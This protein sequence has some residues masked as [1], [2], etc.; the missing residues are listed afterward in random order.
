MCIDIEEYKIKNRELTMKNEKLGLS[1]KQ[2]IYLK[3]E[4]KSFGVQSRLLSK[5]HLE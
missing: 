3:S 4:Y 2:R 1:K 5:T